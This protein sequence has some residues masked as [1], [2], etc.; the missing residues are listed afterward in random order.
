[1]TSPEPE[2]RQFDALTTLRA[3]GHH[4]DLL[5]ERQRQVFAELSEPEVELL[6]SIKTRLDAVAGEVEGH[7]LKLV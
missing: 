7:D 3:A 2:A 1:M 4:V 6:I 5:S